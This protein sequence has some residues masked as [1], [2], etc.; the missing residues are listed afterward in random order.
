MPSRKDWHMLEKS[1]VTAIL[2]YLRSLPECFCWKQHGSQFGVSGLPDIICCFGGRFLAF[3]VKRPA[4]DGH[5][6]GKL[7]MLQEST[8]KRIR[9]A[10]GYAYKVTSLQEVR[11]IVQNLNS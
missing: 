9:A 11:E 1:I 10:K 7:T 8:L 4:G 2:K 3:E 6:S 5:P